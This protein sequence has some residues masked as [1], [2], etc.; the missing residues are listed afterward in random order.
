MPIPNAVAT[1]PVIYLYSADFSE[2]TPLD[3]VPS[4]PSAFRLAKTSLT[5]VEPFTV[6]VL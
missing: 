3:I 1:V 5:V 2:I 6:I 4:I